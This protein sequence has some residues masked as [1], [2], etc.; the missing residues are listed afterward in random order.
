MSDTPAIKCKKC[1]HIFQPD[2]KT[3]KPWDCPSCH[4]KNPN[5][6]RHYRSVA[7]LFILGFIITAI[8]IG[9]GINKEGLSLGYLLAAG[10][11]GLLLVTI[12]FIIK[13]KTPWT[14]RVAK[15]LIWTVFGLA[16]IFNLVLPLLLDGALNIPAIVVYGLVI[17]YLVWLN[18][19]AAKCTVSGAFPLPVKEES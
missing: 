14:D 10:H 8:T 15:A 17:L 12:V 9:M 7:D 6:K 19:Q 11:S 2:M 4:K 16:I 1:G 13:S 5:L 18:L 3:R